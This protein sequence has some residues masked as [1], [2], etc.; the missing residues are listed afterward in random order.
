MDN[1]ASIQASLLPDQTTCQ[2]FKEEQLIFSS[3]SHWLHP[4]FELKD[5]LENH[6]ELSCP[7]KREKLFLRDRI[8]GRAAALMIVRMNIIHCAA[9]IISERAIP[10]FEMHHVS[11]DYD[12]TVSRLPCQTEDILSEIT[13]PLE[14][15]KIL[16]QRASAAREAQ[17]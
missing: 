17:R 6:N 10:I 16:E 15:W 14:A 1:S 7:P 11:V 3:Q 5:F 4:L 9:P 8:I 13:D 12:E 2:V